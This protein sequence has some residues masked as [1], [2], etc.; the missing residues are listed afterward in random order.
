MMGLFLVEK[1]LR[2]DSAEVAITGV[3]AEGRR[4]RI[5]VPAS[6]AASVRPGSALLLQWWTA[7]VP[8]MSSAITPAAPADEAA[9]GDGIDV[10]ADATAEAEA[11]AE[12]AH[13]ERVER[14]F[15]A[16]IG[17]A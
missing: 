8:M 4:A 5:E 2:G 14:E 9:E 17:L 13:D 6:A 10:E 7:E 15:R 1:V 16:L 11:E 3:D 12:V